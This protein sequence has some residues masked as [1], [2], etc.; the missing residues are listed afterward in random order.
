MIKDVE[1]VLIATIL[2]L[3]F[4]IPS[5]S[6]LAKIVENIFRLSLGGS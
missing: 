3:G 5:S 2:S 6:K 1:N 4:F